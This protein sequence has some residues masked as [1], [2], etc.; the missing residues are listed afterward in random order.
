MSRFRV[1]QLNMQFGEVWDETCPDRAPIHLEETIAE[2]RR[3]QADLV[4]L[5][6]VEQVLPGGVQLQPPR[7][8]T[9]L[10][11]ELPGYAGHFGYPKADPRELPFGIGL[12]IFSRTPLRD[13]LRVDLP[14]PPI[15][16]EF[17]GRKT[18]P[19]DRLLI[20]ARTTIHGR[21]LQLLNTHLL[22]FFM[23]GSSSEAH[24]Q[25]RQ[26]VAQHLAAARGPCV[27][28]GDFNVS[29]HGSLVAQF[30]ACG[31]RTVQEHEIT[32]RRRPF[33]L[34][35][36]FHNAP[37]R[38]VGCQVVPTRASDHHAIVADFEFAQGSG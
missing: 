10:C 19:T 38:C 24:P 7:N 21:E 11:A 33:V 23:L 25:Q 15:E 34:D 4:M 32:W 35:H 1:L 12:A 36:V 17:Q 22:A 20:G 26:I 16:F 9:R 5:Q 28:A 13:P 31:F 37:L 18:T 3:H 30:A 14:S 6:E 27:L 29:R 8:Y 2:I